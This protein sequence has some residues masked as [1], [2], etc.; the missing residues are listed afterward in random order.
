MS[1]IVNIAKGVVCTQESCHSTIHRTLNGWN[2]LPAKC[3]KEACA[4][5]VDANVDVTT[6]RVKKLACISDIY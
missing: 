4:D 1:F 5:N 2:R 6:Y 3:L